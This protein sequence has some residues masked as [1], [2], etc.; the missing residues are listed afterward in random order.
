MTNKKWFEFTE[1]EIRA[2]PKHPGPDDK[3]YFNGKL[4]RKGH[5]SPKYRLGSSCAQ[6]QGEK[7]R[8]KLCRKVPEAAKVRHKPVKIKGVTAFRVTV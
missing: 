6:C 4:C 1:D 3:F 2:L 8:V 5:F 7:V